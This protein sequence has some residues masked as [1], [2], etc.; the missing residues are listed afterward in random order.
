MYIFT[1]CCKILR[2][3]TKDCR[4]DSLW[5]YP[6]GFQDLKIKTNSELVFELWVEVLYLPHHNL[7]NST[8]CV[9]H[10]EF[11][12]LTSNRAQLLNKLPTRSS[13]LGPVKFGLW[14]LWILYYLHTGCSLLGPY[15]VAF[16]T[17]PS[18]ER[19]C[20]YK[21]NFQQQWKIN[22]VELCHWH[23]IFFYGTN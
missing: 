8:N 11:Y 7:G 23:L 15:R 19:L 13:R 20:N 16:S 12:D 14:G 10:I 4:I 3:N 5:Q 6:T 17:W 22:S 9:W 18:H 21:L 2:G 1:V